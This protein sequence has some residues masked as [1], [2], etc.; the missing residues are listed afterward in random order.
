MRKA[1]PKSY[2]P[3]TPATE[4]A[5]LDWSQARRVVFPGLKPTTTTTS[6]RLPVWMLEELRTLANQRDVSYQSLLKTILADRLSAE[7]KAA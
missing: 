3:D 1:R 6:L 2:V 7:G 5:E 4:G